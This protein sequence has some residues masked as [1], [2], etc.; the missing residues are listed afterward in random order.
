MTIA[1]RIIEK[2]TNPKHISIAC[3][4]LA[5]D[6]FTSRNKVTTYEFADGSLLYLHPDGKA[7]ATQAINPITG[8]AHRG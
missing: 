5:T 4:S 2:L 3:D 8:E 1:T 6:S 7:E